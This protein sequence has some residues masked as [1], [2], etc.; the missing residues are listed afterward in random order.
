MSIYMKIFF[1]RYS[2]PWVSYNLNILDLFN[3]LIKN[4]SDLKGEKKLCY[5]IRT[6]IYSIRIINPRTLSFIFISR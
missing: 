5:Y 2:R 4:N 6:L 1:R 3:Y